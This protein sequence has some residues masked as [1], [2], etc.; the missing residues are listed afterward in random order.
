MSEAERSLSRVTKLLIA[1]FLVFL[2]VVAV[3]T[4]RLAFYGDQ[5]REEK[6]AAQAGQAAEQ[7]DKKDLAE[8]VKKVCDAGGEPAKKLTAQG[9]CGKAKEIIQ[10]PIAGLPGE[11]GEQGPPPSDDQV[12]RAVSL[13]CSTGVCRGPSGPGGIPGVPGRPGVNG[14]PPTPA[15]VAAAVSAFCNARGE[16]RGPEGTEGDKGDP[17]D[18]GTQG[19]RGPGPTDAQVLGAVQSYCGAESQPCKGDKGDKG[20]PGSSIK[21]DKGDSGM[22]GTD[23]VPFTFKFTIPANPPFSPDETTYR[24]FIERPDT[25]T[26]CAVVPDEPPPTN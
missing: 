19:E 5:Q 18:Q 10:E 14:Q 8:E 26:T 17:G 7:A 1:V 21:G 23:A 15:Q 2:A 3:S 20:D 25:V 22:N 13:Y 16:C 9:L 6:Q 24:C 4:V 11:Q 12:Q